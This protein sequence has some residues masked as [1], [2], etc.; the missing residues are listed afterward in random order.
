LIAALEHN[1]HGHFESLPLHDLNQQCND[2]C[3]G[4]DE[5]MPESPES[6]RRYIFTGP[7]PEGVQVPSRMAPRARTDSGSP[8]FRPVSG[9]KDPSAAR[10]AIL[11]ESAAADAWAARNA[12][13]LV[14]AARDAMSIFIRSQGRLEYCEAWTLPAVHFQRLGSIMA[15]WRGPAGPHSLPADNT[16][17]NDLRE[18]AGLLGLTW[19][20]GGLR[21]GF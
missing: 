15:D 3:P 20:E 21:A 2:F 1:P 13:R 12:T 14:V 7:L 17:A 16:S 10:L 8:C 9:F 19:N 18:L 6:L 4:F 5:D 11:A